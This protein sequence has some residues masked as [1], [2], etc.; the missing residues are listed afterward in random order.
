MPPSN[1]DETQRSGLDSIRCITLLSCALAIAAMSAPMA[2]A[3]GL[4]DIETFEQLESLDLFAA[5]ISA[6][7]ADDIPRARA[8]LEQALGTSGAAQG[9]AEAERAIAAA[10]TRERERI[11]LEEE[12]RLAAEAEE[13]RRADEAAQA[14]AAAARSGSGS[15][16]TRSGGGCIIVNADCTPSLLNV[17]FVEDV[18]VSGGP[19]YVD[20]GSSTASICPDVNG[21]IAG[22]YGFTIQTED[23]ICSGQFPVSGRARF[24]VT[25]NIYED[26][27]AAGP[28]YEY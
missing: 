23:R 7:E 18:N 9:R 13:R 1:A 26:C 14:A 25:I 28:V 15:G 20:N 22:T 5:A 16:G 11:R 27:R 21:R 17:C 24:T 3:L 12:R 10:E 2:A 8:L 4:D 19:G 6:A